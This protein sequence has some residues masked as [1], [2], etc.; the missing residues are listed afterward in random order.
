LLP[1]DTVVLDMKGFEVLSLEDAI[2][3]ATSSAV[4]GADV[5]VLLSLPVLSSSVSYRNTTSQLDRN[6][7][8]SNSSGDSSSVLVWW[9]YK[10]GTLDASQPSSNFLVLQAI[11]LGTHTI[12][13]SAD[14][15][16]RLPA[17]GLPPGAI[18]ISSDSPSGPIA[19]TYGW[20]AGLG[21]FYVKYLTFAPPQA[22]TQ[23]GIV[24]LLCLSQQMRAQE[25]LTLFL[26]GFGLNASMHP[27]GASP[28]ATGVES[29]L[30]GEPISLEEGSSSSS[31]N[32]S[33]SGST[34]AELAV[35]GFV[36]EQMGFGNVT[37]LYEA[38]QRVVSF[39][40]RN[41]SS[42]QVSLARASFSP[43]SPFSLSFSF[44]SHSHCISFTRTLS[45]SLR[46]TKR[47]C[48]CVPASRSRARARTH[49]HIHT[50]L[51]SLPP[52]LPSLL[53]AR[54][55]SLSCARAFYMHS[56]IS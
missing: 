1:G 47:A 19:P 8:S 22:G 27:T 51:P 40:W 48:V 33:G 25:E 34:P 9:R 55:L 29:C 49:T 26:P 31:G 37:A 52:S 28:G 36:R 17:Q 39:E 20:S 24:M 4:A 53:R 18:S 30:F 5:D 41:A 6:S 35:A 16:I 23:S 44:L 7:T 12:E 45:L 42:L 14:L 32:T 10:K 43:F 21:E 46:A 13:L 3:N 15:G 50:L 56:L 38:L 11:T 54:D 2:V